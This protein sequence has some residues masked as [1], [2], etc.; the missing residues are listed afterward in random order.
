MF[1][2]GVD[3]NINPPPQIKMMQ[4]VTG[5]G[6]IILLNVKDHPQVCQ[7]QTLK[8]LFPWSPKY[9][10]SYIHDTHEPLYRLKMHALIFAHPFLFVCSLFKS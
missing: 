4:F 9:T 2:A 10:H 6:G 1:H 5:G 3:I 8:V 7:V